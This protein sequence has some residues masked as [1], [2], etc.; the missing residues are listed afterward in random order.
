MAN[1]LVIVSNRVPLPSSSS[2]TG[3]LAPLLHSAL[4]GRRPVLWFGWSGRVSDDPASVV[5]LWRRG[6]VTFVGIDLSPIQYEGYLNG[7]SHSALW[8]LLHGVAE[9][10]RFQPDDLALYRGVNGLFAARLAA[11]LKPDDEIWI[12]DYH[13]IPLGWMLRQSGVEVPI[14]FFLHTPFPQADALL[15]WPWHRKL[16]V[17]FSAYDLVGFQSEADRRRFDEFRWQTPRFGGR[18]RSLRP[19]SGTFP[20]GIHTRGCRDMAL[21]PVTTSKALRL[22]QSLNYRPLLVSAGRLD[23]TSGVM[24]RFRAFELML[25]EWPAA[26]RAIHLVEVTAPSRELVPGY[27][28]FQMEQQT[29]AQ[30]INER[31]GEG[32]WMPIYDLRSALHRR[33]LAALFRLGRAGLVTPLSGGGSLMAREFIAAQDPRDPGVLVVSQGSGTTDLLDGAMEV[34]PTDV[35][36]FAHALR[37]ALQM[38]LDERQDRWRRMMVKLMHHDAARWHEEFLAALGA[39]HR[40]TVRARMVQESDAGHLGSAPAAPP[41]SSQGLGLA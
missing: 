31:F 4:E 6:S 37:M 16:A 12:Q 29:L 39:A 10:I 3:G 35:A 15:S 11:M 28:E 26:R 27:L 34:E 14:G 23:Y 21:S 38:P 7:F 22:G 25:E 30:R 20:V 8:P 18:G 19:I 13:L 24:E 33:P 1:R 32:G 5:S 17:D 36:E 9:R 40:A 41:A 2:L